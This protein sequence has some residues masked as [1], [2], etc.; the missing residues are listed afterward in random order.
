MQR[1]DTYDKA[2]TIIDLEEHASL[3]SHQPAMMASNSSLVQYSGDTSSDERKLKK[4][5]IERACDFCRRR[6]TKCDGPKMKDNVCTNC[7]QTGRSCTYIES[8]K[9]R[10]PPKAYITALED[11]VE[12]MEVLLRRLRPEADFSAELGPPVVRDSWKSDAPDTQYA[13]HHLPTSS[14]RPAFSASTSRFQSLLPLATAIPLPGYT[15]GCC[16]FASA[17]LEESSASLAKPKRNRRSKQARPSPGMHH[18]D[19]SSSEAPL[20][21]SDHDDSSV[22]LS[23]VQ[24]LTQLTLRGLRP[25]HVTSKEPQ[26]GQWRYHGKS[27]TF[28]LIH[29][30]RELKQRHMDEVGATAQ[31]SAPVVNSGGECCQTFAPRRP[32]FWQS[33][34]WEISF[35]GVD[36]ST[37]PAFLMSH[38]PPMDL[39]NSLVE[40]YFARNNSLFPLLH[41]PNFDKHWNQGLYQNDVWFAC[42]CMAMFAVASRWSDDARVLPDEQ[43]V[44][45]ISDSSGD[46]PW[47]LAGW[48][49]VNAALDV[50]RHRRSLFLPTNL[51]EVQTL[52]LMA[53]YFRG[54]VAHSESWTLISIG[55]RKAQDVGAHRK[56]VYGRKPTVEEELWKRA[57]WHLIA[58]DRLGSM[59]VGRS[60]CCRE[61]DFDLDLPLEVDDE[62][63]END[64]P[65]LAFQQPEGK[66]ALVTAFVFWVKLSRITAFALRTLYAIGRSKQP[67]GLV[68]PRWKED[69]V[70]R[71]NEAMLEWIDSIPEHLKWTPRMEI[72]VFASQS[73]ILHMSYYLL[74]IAVY[75]PFMPVPHSMA[76]G[77]DSQEHSA[78]SSEKHDESLAA[79]SICTNAAKA[80]SHILV[81]LL[82]RGLPRHTVVVHYA[83]VYAGVLLVNMWM[84]IAKESGREDRRR[85]TRDR[86]LSPAVQ[87]QTGDLLQLLDIMN[88]MRPRWELAREVW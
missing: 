66:P 21:A 7:V 17:K 71:L 85:R 23:L 4:R 79:L 83:F 13:G 58:M 49:Y 38:W 47:A 37:T 29:A 24:G 36:R 41:R 53:M 10:G 56:K 73:A 30:T 31:P 62:Y 65:N 69:T 44:N 76:I 86:A 55:I 51:F 82:G 39:A 16:G 72:D 25:A 48:K 14:E 9:P 77:G 88:S 43:M 40:L 78:A 64:D 18:S 20:S 19:K 11:R 80:G 68:G 2:S 3:D 15:Y 67:L 54:T 87:A 35:E 63:W 74:Q 5:K 57:V 60:C 70:G 45:N 61:E 50:H 33:L 27:S 28:K 81:V 42:V 22:E 59:L 52:V 6:K 12:K 34:P 8:S 26:D 32:H 75:R 84:Q 1:T 46:G